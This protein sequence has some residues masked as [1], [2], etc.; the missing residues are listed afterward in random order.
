M[1]ELEQEENASQCQHRG[2]DNAA[3]KLGHIILHLRN[4]VC[5]SCHQRA[6]TE[7]IHLRK[8]KAHDPAKAVLTDVVSNVLAG[9]VGENVV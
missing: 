8:G 3:D 9:H 5:D 7:S 2:A 4:V 1:V 6:G